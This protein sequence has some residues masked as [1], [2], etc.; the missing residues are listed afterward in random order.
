MRP[1]AGRTEKRCWSCST[2]KPL[3][4]FHKRTGRGDGFN[5]TCKACRKAERQTRTPE[6]IAAYR[7]SLRKSQS[8]PAHRAARVAYMRE[9]QRRPD[10]KARHKARNAVKDALRDGRMIRPPACQTCGEKATLDAHHPDY[11]KPLLVYWI[12]RPCHALLHSESPHSFPNSPK[13][14]LFVELARAV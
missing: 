2:T 4:E 14:A 7:A 10:V 1:V 9:Y 6:Q 13:S 12:C 3:A 5:D 11:A 8:N